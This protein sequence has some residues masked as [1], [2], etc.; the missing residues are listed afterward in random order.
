MKPEEFQRRVALHRDMQS[1]GNRV[2][3]VALLETGL[4][5]SHDEARRCIKQEQVYV[6]DLP[7]FDAHRLLGNGTHKI[8]LGDRT[9]NLT[10]NP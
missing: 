2:L 1:F 4:V 5:K 3:I 8:R 6:N 7:V 9:V 10:L